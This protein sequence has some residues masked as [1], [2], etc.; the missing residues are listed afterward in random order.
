MGARL[1]LN[2]TGFIFRDDD[3][4]KDCRA[5]AHAHDDVAPTIVMDG[6]D[7]ELVISAPGSRRIPTEIVQTMVYLLDYD[8]SP[9]D[10]VR[11]RIYPSPQNARPAQHSYSALTL[12]EAR[13]ELR[14]RASGAGLC[15]TVFRE[16]G[17]ESL[18]RSRGSPPRRRG[19]RVLTTGRCRVLSSRRTRRA[20]RSSR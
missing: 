18:G 7:V 5:V 2:G 3:A 8:M 11:M 13:A 6:N 20:P 12:R 15:S 14:P 17:R 19:P 9:L 1:L 16:A 10:A 4:L